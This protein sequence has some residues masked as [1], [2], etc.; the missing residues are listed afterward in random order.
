M[1]FYKAA[2]GSKLAKSGMV[3]TG[4]AA[5]CDVR[6]GGSKAYISDYYL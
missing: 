5:V 6:G 1:T 3:K 2:T 4:S